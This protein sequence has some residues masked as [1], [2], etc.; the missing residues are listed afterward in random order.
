MRAFVNWVFTLCLFESYGIFEPSAVC[1]VCLSA[2]PAPFSLYS[3]QYL[4]IIG[5]LC[6][7][8][9]ILIEVL[10]MQTDWPAIVTTLQ[11]TILKGLCSYFMQPLDI[12]KNI[13]RAWHLFIVGALC[14]LSRNTWHFEI[15]SIRTDWW[16]GLLSLPLLPLYSAVFNGPS[17]YLV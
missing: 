11:P 7:F 9:G 5:F 4:S 2:G 15:L 3:L 14:W 10:S 13:V 6:L 12:L 16:S 8:S 1:P 17:S